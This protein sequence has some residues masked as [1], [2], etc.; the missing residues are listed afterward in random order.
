MYN[1]R[2]HDTCGYYDY[3]FKMVSYDF[4]LKH[5]PSA[6]AG[7]NYDITNNGYILI[8]YTTPI[9]EL[10]IL[11]DNTRYLVPIAKE[12]YSNT[13]RKHISAFLKEYAPNITYQEAKKCIENSEWLKVA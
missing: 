1:K 13:T 10:R 2:I 5:M 4:N 8:S 6:S 12:T 11:S 3:G 7:V 9:V